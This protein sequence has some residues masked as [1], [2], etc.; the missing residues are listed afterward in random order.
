MHGR[1]VDGRTRRHPVRRLP[2]VELPSQGEAVHEPADGT[3]PA[4]VRQFLISELLEDDA[5][6]K[7][8]YLYLRRSPASQGHVLAVG[9]EQLRASASGRGSIMA[10]MARPVS[11][12]HISIAVAGSPGLASVT[13]T[14]PWGCSTNPAL[15]ERQRKPAPGG[16]VPADEH[17]RRASVPGE[18]EQALAVGR[19]AELAHVELTAVGRDYAIEG[20]YEAG[21]RGQGCRQRAPGRGRWQRAPALGCQEQR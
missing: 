16:E 1:H 18:R 17:A 11:T 13:T 12:L 10:P 4:R 6:V 20:R 3:G 15:G 19:E 5:P 7:G 9:H 2:T 14:W 8:P 21:M